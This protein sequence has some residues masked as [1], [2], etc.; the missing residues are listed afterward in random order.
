MGYTTTDK[1]WEDRDMDQTPRNV[2]D[3]RE[4]AG[5]TQQEAAL[6]VGIS[7]SEFDNAEDGL[8]PLPDDTWRKFVGMAGCRIFDAGE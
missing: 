4:R 3:V 6:V 7:A 5:W 2:R 1:C 8:T